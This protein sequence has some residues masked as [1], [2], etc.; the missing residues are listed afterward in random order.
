MGFR[1]SPE[2]L[3]RHLGPDYLCRCPD[4]R[5]GRLI[6]GTIQEADEQGFNGSDLAAELYGAGTR[7]G[8]LL[9]LLRVDRSHPEW[10]EAARRAGRRVR[11]L[12]ARPAVKAA[13]Y[14]RAR[15]E[16]RSRKELLAE[17][18]PTAAI[19]ALARRSEPQRIRLGWT[20]IKDRH[21]ATTSVAPISPWLSLAEFE[22][23]FLKEIRNALEAHLLDDAY[24][25][26]ASDPLDDAELY[27]RFRDATAASESGGS[28]ERQKDRRLATLQTLP[29]RLS[30][31]ERDVYQLLEQNPNATS[32]ELGERL[33]MAPGTVRVQKGRI[34]KKAQELLAAT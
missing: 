28:A 11:G 8:D 6:R 15:D 24:P 12:L 34:R 13:L 25:K 22:L 2:K 14:D 26:K 9:V 32:A 10:M 23:W 31:R 19:L 18:L 5:I 30:R 17:L 16:D 27:G 20:W 7:F 33:N 4:T 3:R 1:F 29:E 21:G